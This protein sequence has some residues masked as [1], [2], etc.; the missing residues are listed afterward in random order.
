MKNYKLENYKS[1]NLNETLKLV[2]L[3]LLFVVNI[4][5]LQCQKGGGIIINISSDLGIRNSDQ[6]IYDQS[7]NIKVKNFKPISY[8]ISKHTIHGIINIFQHIGDIKM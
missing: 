2:Y 8:S 6:R 1:E 7:E 5:V 4:L 3:E